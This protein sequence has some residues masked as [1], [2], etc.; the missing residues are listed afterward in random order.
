MR[1]RFI[2]EY[3]NGRDTIT[4]LGCTFHGHEPREIPPDVEALLSGHPEFE[5]IHLLDHDGDG[6]KG[7]SLPKRRGRPRKVKANG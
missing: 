2:G 4:Y 1:L 7:G 3:T 6:V 5:V